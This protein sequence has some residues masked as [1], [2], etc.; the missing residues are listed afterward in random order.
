MLGD[1]GDSTIYRNNDIE[2]VAKMTITIVLVFVHCIF[3]G[4]MGGRE[5]SNCTNTVVNT[6]SFSDKSNLLVQKKLMCTYNL[7]PDKTANLNTTSVVILGI[8]VFIQL[9]RTIE[10]ISTIEIFSEQLS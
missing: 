5:A 8:H 10:I 3:G 4:F 7:L 6:S 9:S 1:S 2:I